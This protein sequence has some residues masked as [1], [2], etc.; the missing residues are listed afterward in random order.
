MCVD[1][2]IPQQERGYQK[3]TS[4]VGPHLLLCWRQGLF[5]A[6]YTRL[7]GPQTDTLLS[8]LPAH[9]L[10][11]AALGFQVLATTVS[12]FFVGSR[13]PPSGHQ[14][15]TASALAIELSPALGIFMSMKVFSSSSIPRAA[16][17]HLLSCGSRSSN[18]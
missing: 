3:T 7:A 9:Y 1:V 5:T 2:C 6:A 16:A 17:V 18:P 13:D 4:G 12:G 10:P 8:P 14:A 15:H 11:V